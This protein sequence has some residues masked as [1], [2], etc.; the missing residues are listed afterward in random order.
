MPQKVESETDKVLDTFTEEQIAEIKEAYNLFPQEKECIKSECVETLL[1]AL[2]HHPNQD[3][4][5]RI[6]RQLHIFNQS[7][8]SFNTFLSVLAMLFA[9]ISEE[10]IR[11]AFR[12]FDKVLKSN[13]SNSQCSH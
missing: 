2:G 6:F 11:Q 3:E 9:S 7:R 5:S 8:V 13:I 1:R 12:M 10:A 4:L